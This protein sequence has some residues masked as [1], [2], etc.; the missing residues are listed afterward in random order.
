MSR[1][2][3]EKIGVRQRLCRGE[4]TAT[5]NSSA[6]K[7]QRPCRGEPTATAAAVVRPNCRLE[8]TT[9]V[10]GRT[11]CNFAIAPTLALGVH[12]TA[13][14]QG[15]TN[16]NSTRW[17]FATPD[18]ACAGANQLQ[19]YRRSDNGSRS[20]AD[21]ACAGANQLQHHRRHVGRIDLRPRQRLCRGEPTATRRAAAIQPSKPG[22]LWR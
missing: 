10:Q 21:N 15:R 20:A 4:P 11:N 5:G 6:R 22:I 14:V 1:P 8:P 2:I 16:C 7:Q 9:P 3:G 17:P 12:P 13:P 18:N 19:L